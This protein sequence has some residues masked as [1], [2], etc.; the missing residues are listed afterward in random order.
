MGIGRIGKAVV[1]AGASA[2]M[3]LT[4]LA[5]A[6]ASTPAQAAP[7]AMSDCSSG[8]VCIWAGESFN[9]TPTNSYYTYGV[10][11]LY[12]QYGWHYIYNHQTGGAKFKLCTGSNGTGCTAP[13]PPGYGDVNLT[14]YNSIV[15]L[16]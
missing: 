14:P 6:S 9:G 10:H 4:G 16:P 3:A 2:A 12:N 11:K 1:V 15:L 8:Y 7:K 5:S 13:L